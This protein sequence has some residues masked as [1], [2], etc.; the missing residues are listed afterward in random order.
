MGASY[1]CVCVVRYVLLLNELKKKTPETMEDYG[2]V[3]K[4]LAKIEKMADY[5]DQENK[6]A[7]MSQ[8]I[9]QL[10]NSLVEKVV[11]TLGNIRPNH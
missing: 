1:I 7:V 5:I 8:R 4:A 6:F 3:C 11:L 10:Q 9:L 2:A